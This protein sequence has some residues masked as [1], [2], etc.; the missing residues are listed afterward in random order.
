MI[1]IEYLLLITILIIMDSKIFL[2]QENVQFRLLQ[3]V[4]DDVIII[5]LDFRSDY[6]IHFYLLFLFQLLRI[7]P[8]SFKVQDFLLFFLIIWG[9]SKVILLHTFCI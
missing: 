7:R 1:C 9:T 4:D 5:T 2:E 3:V 6:P 8:I